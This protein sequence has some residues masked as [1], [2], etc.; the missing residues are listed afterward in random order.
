MKIAELISAGRESSPT[1][2]ILVFFARFLAASLVLYLI[3]IKLGVH[4]AKLIS[5]GAS[6]L[7]ALFGH[8][9]IISRAMSITEDIALNPVVFLSLVIAVMNIPIWERVRGAILGLVILTAANSITVALVFLSYY[10]DSE[11]L[12]TGT[13][14]FNLTINF[15]LPLLL[16]Y[17]LLPVRSH[18]PLGMSRKTD[19][20]GR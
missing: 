4:Y 15:F 8:R 7:V 18:L 11:A 1:R 9:V 13:E 6:P 12:W 10:R 3:Y 16:A 14:F 2:W 20:A 19:R 17:A 5:H